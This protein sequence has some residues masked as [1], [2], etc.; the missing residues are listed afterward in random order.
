MT[1]KHKIL[2][3][4]ANILVGVLICGGIVG[5]YYTY[6]TDDES[7]QKKLTD[8]LAPSHVIMHATH[9]GGKHLVTMHLKEVE[10]LRR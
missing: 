9:Y 5:V 10:R 7:D 8:E 2:I 6:N 3:T 4:I 1:M